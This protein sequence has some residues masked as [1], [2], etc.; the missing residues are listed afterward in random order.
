MV[1][2]RHGEPREAEY[3]DALIRFY[4]GREDVREEYDIYC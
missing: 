3:I 4:D 1:E 2:E